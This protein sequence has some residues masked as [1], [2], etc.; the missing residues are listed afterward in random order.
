MMAR[1]EDVD[2]DPK[3]NGAASSP[4]HRPDDST[5]LPDFDRDFITEEDLEE[6][7]KALEAPDFAGDDDDASSV[8]ITALN[9]WKPVHQRVRARDEQKRSRRAGLGRDETREG[10][11]YTLL[12]WPLLVLVFSWIVVLGVAYVSTRFYV[13]FY[14]QY[15]ALRGRRQ[16]LRRKMQA[17]D[18]YDDWIRAAK[19]L[20]DYLGNEEWKRRDHYAYYDSATVR[21][22]RKDMKRARLRAETMER[23]SEKD[24]DTPRA[25]EDLRDLVEACA[26]SSFAGIENPR[27][28]SETY[29]GTKNLVQ[30]YVEELEA[31]LSFLL[32]TKQLTP[33]EK[34]PLFKHIQTNLGRTALCLSGGACFAYY[35]FGVVKALLDARLLP[36]V[37]SGTSG[38]AIVA[39]LAGTRT[40][41]ELRKLLVPALAGRITACHDDL[42]T[43][44]KRF[45]RTGARFDPI[46]WARRASWFTKG[47]LTFREAYELTGRILNVTCVPSD[48]HSPNILLNYLTSPDCVI[49]SATLASA[50]VP[51]VLSPVPLMMKRRDGTLTPYSFGHKWK[52]GSLRTDIPLKALHAQFNCKFSII[53]QVN[54]HIKAFFFHPRGSVGHPVTHRRGRGWR[55]GFLGSSVEQFLRLD[56]MKWLTI[57]RHLELLPRFY[58]FDWTLLF[59]QH[60]STGTIN[61]APKSVLS[62]FYYILSDPTPAR[63]ARMLH[64]GQ[65]AMFPALKFTSNRLRI[66]RLVDQGRRD[67]RSADGVLSHDDLQ[68]L[69]RDS[70][71]LPSSS[72]AALK[73]FRPL[74]ARRSSSALSLQP[75]PAYARKPPSPHLETAGTAGT[76]GGTSPTKTRSGTMLPNG[77]VGPPREPRRQGSI[78]AEISRQSR[79]FYDDTDHDE[80][81]SESASSEGDPRHRRNGTDGTP[82]DDDDDDD[83]DDDERLYDNARRM[84]GGGL[85]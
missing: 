35:H 17:A 1:R 63:L 31:S 24:P 5:A 69:L 67:T 56:L 16:K 51:G 71:A 46:D 81:I 76:S 33:K 38:G 64:V 28:Y 32:R 29:Y 25:V 66:E 39:A 12:K 77:G 37:I 42:Y 47:S 65:Q 3:S 70:G 68:N 79:V 84:K 2:G 74:V 82:D 43:W 58:G 55:G 8:F 45:Y 7:A 73:S 14:E 11:V 21:R 57:L 62:D 52:D 85:N 54:P 60:R 9:D 50:A 20:D 23:S 75:V 40:D 15:I 72:A 61:I 19:A 80:D 53:S 10:V 22:V 49:W 26:K 41:D 59:L 83:E 78:I 48:P 44:M 36:E 13:W 27:L 34:R 6:F 30:D 4:P 18:N